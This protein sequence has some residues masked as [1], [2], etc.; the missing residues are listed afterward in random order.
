MVTQA[1]KSSQPVL[2]PFRRVKARSTRDWLDVD[3]N[4][5]Q[6]PHKPRGTGG[7]SDIPEP[8]KKLP[9]LSPEKL[10][11]EADEHTTPHGVGGGKGG[12]G[13]RE[14]NQ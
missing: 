13:E 1:P 11:A 4:I 9:L 3:G 6:Q 10:W 5:D 2:V 8:R 14:G 12:G 7:V